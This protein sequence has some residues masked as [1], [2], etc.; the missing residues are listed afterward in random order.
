VRPGPLTPWRVLSFWVPA[1]DQRRYAFSSIRLG[2]TPHRACCGFSRRLSNAKARS[3]KAAKNT[4]SL[5]SWL[6]AFAAW[7]L[8]DGKQPAS[9]RGKSEL[10]SG[11]RG[12][13][14][15]CT[16]HGG[17]GNS[18]LA[19][20]QVVAPA[21][22]DVWSGVVDSLDVA[23]IGRR[24]VTALPQ[25]DGAWLC[26]LSGCSMARDDRET[27]H[28]SA[29]QRRKGQSGQGAPRCR[30]LTQGDYGSDCISSVVP[31]WS[32]LAMLTLESYCAPG[33]ESCHSSLREGLMGKDVSV[34]RPRGTGP[35]LRLTLP[36]SNT[37]TRAPYTSSARSW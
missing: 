1:A 28:L 18:C 9:A 19:A 29:P 27:N 8:C 34:V 37:R 36:K 26:D 5:L 16:D 31:I 33:R 14:S 17:V 7:R 35:M 24:D 15:R 22:G 3:R 20:Q 2:P 6:C 32:N 4:M 12:T 10:E 23:G 11:Q 13:T 30:R 21:D 25:A